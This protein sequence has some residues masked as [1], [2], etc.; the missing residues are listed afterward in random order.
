MK[1]K[2]NT[3]QEETSF[4]FQN[5]NGIYIKDY[6]VVVVSLLAITL[7]IHNISLSLYIKIYILYKIDIFK[8]KKAKNSESFSCLYTTLN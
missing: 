8:V 3:I 1:Q 5:S 6:K 7:F 2:Y 4:S